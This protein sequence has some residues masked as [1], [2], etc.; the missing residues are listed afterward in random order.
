ML[1]DG[2]ESDWPASRLVFAL[3]VDGSPSVPR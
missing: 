2:N 3:L 1:L